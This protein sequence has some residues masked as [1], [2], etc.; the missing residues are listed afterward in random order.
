[1]RL[2]KKPRRLQKPPRKKQQ[3]WAPK[4]NFPL[5]YYLRPYRLNFPPLPLWYTK[6]CAAAKNPNNRKK[7]P[8]S[9]RMTKKRRKK[10]NLPATR[11]L[12]VFRAAAAINPQ[13]Q[14][15][16]SHAKTG[17]PASTHLTA[18]NCL[19]RPKVP[20]SVRWPTPPAPLFSPRA[21]L[22]SRGDKCTTSTKYVWKIHCNN[23]KFCSTTGRKTFLT[24]GRL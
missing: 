5:D 23:S 20:S 14:T 11:P 13:R 1:M 6:T 10:W 18:C 7:N 15:L 4:T 19:H 17:K 16:R 8:Q 21:T 24:R 2:L 3:A 12:L 22:P 9:I